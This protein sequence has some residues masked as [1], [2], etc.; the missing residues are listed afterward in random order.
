MAEVPAALG[1]GGIQRCVPADGH[2][3]VLQRG[4]RATVGVDVAGGHA[5]HSDPVGQPG[6]PAVAG[7]IVAQIG[8]LEL[9]AQPVRTKGL[10]QAAQR[11]LVVDAPGGTARQ[12]DQPGGAIEDVLEGD[13]GLAG[14]PGAALTRVRVGAC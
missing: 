12:A 10:E 5:G 3:R 8:A 14:R 11:P 9:D 1:L 2:E 7:P 4:A 13:M 6:Q